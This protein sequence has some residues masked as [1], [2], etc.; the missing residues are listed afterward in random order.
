[1]PHTKVCRCE[2]LRLEVRPKRS[3]DT[4]TG[5]TA[6]DTLDTSSLPPGSAGHTRGTDHIFRR[7][8]MRNLVVGPQENE[9]DHNGDDDCVVMEGSRRIEDCTDQD[10]SLALRGGLPHTA[11]MSTGARRLYSG[12]TNDAS[13]VEDL[14]HAEIGAL[15]GR[16]LLWCDPFE[17]LLYL[18]S[19]E[20]CI[21]SGI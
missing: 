3:H 20:D 21:N 2:G 9:N 4:S 11:P 5:K 14:L 16:T 10:Q 12:K 13:F 6:F 19:N 17:V 15:L 18:I 1:M 7:G 8:V